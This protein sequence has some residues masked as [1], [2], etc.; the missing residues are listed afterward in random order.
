[1]PL[2][3]HAAENYSGDKIGEG[4]IGNR[5]E[6]SVDS[7]LSTLSANRHEISGVVVNP[8][9]QSY[10]S[11][12]DGIDSTL[13]L[14]CR[15]DAP[16]AATVRRM[17]T[18]AIET[19]KKGLWGRAYVDG[20]HNTTPGFEVGDRWLAEIV[21]QLHKVGV[22]VVYEDTPALFPTG[23]PMSDCALYYGGTH[24]DQPDRSASLIFISHRA[25]SRSTS[26]RSARVLCAIRT[27]AGSHRC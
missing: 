4:P 8:F 1:M 14:V 21:E 27:Q 9:F 6:A 17:I 11:I 12:R 22:P 7:E 3:I 23:Y 16:T 25:P 2:K 19:E 15:L 26:I 5:N 13:L 20:A 18:D 10:R 24:P